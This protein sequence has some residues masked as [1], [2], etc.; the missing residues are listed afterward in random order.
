MDRFTE[1]CNKINPFIRKEE[2]A[3]FSLFPQE[4]IARY[5]ILSTGIALVVGSI[6]GTKCIF[7]ITIFGTVYYYRD[8]I[9]K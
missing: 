9:M 8:I 2:P 6:I 3:Q 5:P 4:F 7:A 1:I